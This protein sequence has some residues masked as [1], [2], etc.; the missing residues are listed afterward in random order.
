MARKLYSGYGITELRTWARDLNIAGRSKMTGDKLVTACKAQVRAN[1]VAA[2][3]AILSVVSVEP[4]TLL[5][6]KS[7]SAVVRVTSTPAPY[8][9]DGVN[10]ESL[11]F[12]AEYVEMGIRQPGMHRDAE[13]QN[14]MDELSA[15][16]G[17]VLQHMLY[18]YEAIP[19]VSIDVQAA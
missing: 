8:V 11:A 12:T 7:T 4:G 6:H 2:E 19:A 18:Q 16:S 3:Q 5:R 10:Y 9:R 13:F 17:Y 15:A 14:R 1:V